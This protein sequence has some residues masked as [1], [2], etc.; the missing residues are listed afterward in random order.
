MKLLMVS[1]YVSNYCCANLAQEQICYHLSTSQFHY[2]VDGALKI[3]VFLHSKY[4]RVYWFSWKLHSNWGKTWVGFWIPKC[5]F[6]L[7]PPQNANSWQERIIGVIRHSGRVTPP[8]SRW[9]QKGAKCSVN[10][11][12]LSL[13]L[14]YLWGCLNLPLLFAIILRPS[15]RKQVYM[16]S[17]QS[18]KELLSDS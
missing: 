2:Y 17:C 16:I 6:L 14:I 1:K 10:R 8:V 3:V 4:F 12:V 9:L 5:S 7:V 15:D 11:K 18:V 13:Y